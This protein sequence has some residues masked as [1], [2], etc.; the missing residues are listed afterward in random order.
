MPEKR[1]Q[2]P[3][4][5]PSAPLLPTKDV[6]A[7]IRKNAAVIAPADVETIVA[8]ADEIL[9]RSA[10]ERS[11]HPLLGRQAR[12]ALH[13]LDDHIQGRSP[14]IPYF[15][16][17]LLAVAL[18]YFLD[19]SDAIPDWLGAVGTSDDALVIELA[20]EMGAAG[21][22]RYCDWKGLAASEVL[23]AQIRR[24]R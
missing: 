15:T 22:Q 17:S 12:F 16:I 20:F 18:F 13:L 10:D 21:I 7:F 8:R 19:K 24:R 14:Q 9:E 5:R 6:R 4:A 3:K 2:R 23:P 11:P 1:V